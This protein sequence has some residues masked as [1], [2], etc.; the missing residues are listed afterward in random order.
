MLEERGYRRDQ[1]RN[2]TRSY[3]TRVLQHPVD[4][5]G[6]LVP[7]HQNYEKAGIKPDPEAQ[8]KRRLGRMKYPEHLYEAKLA[9]WRAEVARQ[10]E[11]ARAK[12][13]G[14][15]PKRQPKRTR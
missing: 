9:S 12:G 10:K 4:E 14:R 13:K 8:W 6:S 7:Q 5:K 3:V 11:R 1:I 15:T 2:L